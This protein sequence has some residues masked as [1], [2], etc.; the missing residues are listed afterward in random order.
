[1]SDPRPNGFL[2]GSPGGVLLRLLLLSLLV[3]ALL[4]QV[5]VGI[6]DVVGWFRDLVDWFANLGFGAVERA[7]RY[8]LTGALIVVPLFL[9]TRL[10]ARR[11]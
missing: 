3:G 9:L 6:A 10:L 5:D 2:G 1:M 7:G 8:L 4:G 11:P